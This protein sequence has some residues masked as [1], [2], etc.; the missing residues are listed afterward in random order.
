M[1]KETTAKTVKQPAS[2][3][4]ETKSLKKAASKPSTIAAST[5]AKSSAESPKAKPLVEIKKNR[6][7]T[8][9]GFKRRFDS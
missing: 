2:E 3:K 4:R 1:A 6:V 9:E 7:L 5:S 8:A